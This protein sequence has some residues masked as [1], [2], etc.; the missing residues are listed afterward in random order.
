MPLD[1]QGLDLYSA[2]AARVQGLDGWTHDGTSAKE[3]VAR[4]GDVLFLSK[5]VGEGGDGQDWGT[6]VDQVLASAASDSNGTTSSALL[7]ALSPAVLHGLQRTQTLL[8]PL[9][10]LPLP[11][12][13]AQHDKQAGPQKTTWLLPFAAPPAAQGGGEV[14]SALGVAAPSPRFGLLAVG[15]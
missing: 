12:T 15:R 1:A 4:S 6:L 7:A 8:L 11:P 14:V 3:R 5:L 9:L 2:F 13:P 10:S